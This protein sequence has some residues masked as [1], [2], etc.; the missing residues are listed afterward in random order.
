MSD[1]RD[2]AEYP[3][4]FIPLR[5]GDERIE[6][7]RYT[8][9]LTARG[10]TVQ[11]Q[12]FAPEELDDVLHEVRSLL[13]DRGRDETQWEVGSAAVAL[14]EPLLARGLVRDSD[15]FAVA[16][17]LTAAP[18]PP[19]PGLRARRVQSAEEYLSAFRV[20]SAAFGGVA[21]PQ[22][23]DMARSEWDA[24][25]VIM[26]A[27]WLQDE[28]VSAG[29]MAPVEGGFALFGGGTLPRA[30][31]RGAY[32]ALIAERWRHAVGEGAPTL[33]TQAGAMSR[34][35]LERLG[36]AAVGRVEMLRDRLI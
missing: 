31:G 22:M 20:Q 12:R 25:T 34:P 30:R 27:V 29:R 15:P 9:C 6:R 26:H 10:A 13:R 32:R 17:A 33:V 36:F 19:P 21:T 3:N 18:P 4:A 5:A 14:V 23:L 7:G 35:I 16:M 28:M 8:R 11:R 2:L 1:L 24:V